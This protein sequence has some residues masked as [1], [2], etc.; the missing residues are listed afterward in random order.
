MDEYH[1][2]NE[3]MI[4]VGV[5]E[6]LQKTRLLFYFRLNEDIFTDWENCNRRTF[7]QFWFGFGFK[8]SVVLVYNEGSVNSFQKIKVLNFSVLLIVFK[9]ES[10][11]FVSFSKK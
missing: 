11:Y 4:L 5:F 1:G 9:V 3:N 6:L 10:V 2:G 8:I 7:F